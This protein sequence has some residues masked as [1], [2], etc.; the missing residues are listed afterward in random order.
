MNCD[1]DMQSFQAGFLRLWGSRM[2][3]PKEEFPVPFA[4]C[5]LWH[6]CCKHPRSGWSPRPGRAAHPKQ[7]QERDFCTDVSNCL[8]DRVALTQPP[9]FPGSCTVQFLYTSPFLWTEREKLPA[10]SVTHAFN[11]RKFIWLGTKE[12]EMQTAVSN[13][14]QQIRYVIPQ[15]PKTSFNFLSRIVVQLWGWECRYSRS[16]VAVFIVS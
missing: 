15:L 6:V 16:S 8:S 14:V 3:L 12:L 1:Q 4:L 13:R 11:V 5:L 9:T 10:Y 2:G 7:H